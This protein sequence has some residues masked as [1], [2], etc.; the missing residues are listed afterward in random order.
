MYVQI[1]V[2]MNICVCVCVCVRVCMYMC[3]ISCVPHK[4]ISEELNLVTRLPNLNLQ[5]YFFCIISLMILVTFGGAGI[6]I[7]FDKP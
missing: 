1:L 5:M 4:N 2:C 3:T 6:D 7:G